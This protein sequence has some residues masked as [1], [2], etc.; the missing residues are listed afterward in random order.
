ML[1]HDPPQNLND[2][3]ASDPLTNM[4]RRTFKGLILSKQLHPE[5]TRIRGAGHFPCQLDIPSD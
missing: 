4:N 2:V 5:W 1:P 3:A